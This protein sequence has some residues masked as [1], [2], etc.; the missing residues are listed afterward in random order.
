M[1]CQIIF[2]Y[3]SLV[4]FTLMCVLL[5]GLCCWNCCTWVE[6]RSVEGPKDIITRVDVSNV[7]WFLSTALSWRNI[8][9]WWTL[10]DGGPAVK[11][12]S[13][14][15][16]FAAVGS[17]CYGLIGSNPTSP[18]VRRT[19]SIN[20]CF[21]RLNMWMIHRLWAHMMEDAPAEV[22]VEIVYHRGIFWTL[23]LLK[24]NANILPL[25]DFKR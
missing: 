25:V 8:I 14:F 5:S 11:A 2:K 1:F 16:R 20:S 23:L 19:W 9:L 4:Q 7:V 6:L 12:L 3:N 22:D 15:C 10:G 24:L 13:W 18:D 21:S 17:V